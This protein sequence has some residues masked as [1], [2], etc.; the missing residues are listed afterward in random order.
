MQA[1][2]RA[3]QV[4]QL[5]LSSVSQLGLSSVSQ[6]GLPA[7]HEVALESTYESTTPAA[8]PSEEEE[9]RLTA[10]IRKDYQDAKVN[11]DFNLKTMIEKRHWSR[12][13]D[14][15]EKGQLPPLEAY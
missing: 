6:L 12:I 3:L 15:T 11:K 8:P 1:Q 9:Q 14:L 2:I 10:Q 5:G 4:E 13:K 7:G